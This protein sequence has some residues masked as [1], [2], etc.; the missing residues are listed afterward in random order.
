MMNTTLSTTLN[1]LA[2]DLRQ[3]RDYSTIFESAKSAELPLSVMPADVQESMLA[4]SPRCETV[5]VTVFTRNGERFF[6]AGAAKGS[7]D[8]FPV[9]SRGF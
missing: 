6:Q 3:D 5:Q 8:G 9:V 7:P 2:A 4:D 1:E